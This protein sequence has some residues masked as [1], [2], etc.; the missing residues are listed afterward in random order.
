MATHKIFCKFIFFLPSFLATNSTL[1]VM[2]RYADSFL[3]ALLMTLFI[4]VALPKNETSFTISSVA[5]ESLSNE[6]YLFKLLSAAKALETFNNSPS[7]VFISANSYIVSFDYRQHYVHFFFFHGN[8]YGVDFTSNKHSPFFFDH[9]NLYGNGRN[10]LAC[11][12]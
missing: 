5:P 4:F 1:Y 10:F 9:Q 11:L 8:Q 12:I 2:I 3:F 7:T 6:G